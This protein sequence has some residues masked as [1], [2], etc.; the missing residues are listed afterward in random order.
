M[1]NDWPVVV[2]NLD[3]VRKVCSRMLRILSREGATPRVS[4]LFF[5]AVIQA[6]LLFGEETWVVTPR[7][8]KTLGG[9]QT[10]LTR[11]LTAYMG[12]TW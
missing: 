5:K 8:G 12:I 1:D 10:Q 3:R 11:R 7:M 9:F 6:L 4:G 2:R